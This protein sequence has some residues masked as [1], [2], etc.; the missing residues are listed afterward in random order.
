MLGFRQLR[1]LPIAAVATLA[2]TSGGVANAAPKLT[3]GITVTINGQGPFA[4]SSDSAAKQYRDRGF[5]VQG[6]TQ[7]DLYKITIPRTAKT[8]LDKL[9]WKTSEPC[10]GTEVLKIGPA[11]D[12]FVNASTP[13]K[14][15]LEAG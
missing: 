14:I 8:G 10:A 15:S 9:G 13:G 6:S 5:I 12:I 4:Y 3:T 7:P 11:V 1:L 2:L